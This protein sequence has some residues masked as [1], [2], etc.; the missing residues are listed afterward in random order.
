[1]Y[2]R[3]T[4][5]KSSLKLWAISVILSKTVQS[6]Q[7]PIGRKLAQSGHPGENSPNPVTL[8][9]WKKMPQ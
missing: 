4:W 9:S 7:L 2:I 8:A 3:F 1:M 6:K 5:G